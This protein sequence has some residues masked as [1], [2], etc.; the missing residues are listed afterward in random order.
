MHLAAHAGHALVIG[1]EGFHS[2]R[3]TIWRHQAGP[4]DEDTGLAEANIGG[5]TPEKFRSDRDQDAALVESVNRI[6]HHGD[7]L[8]GQARVDPGLERRLQNRALQN[9]MRRVGNF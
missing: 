8:S 4:A 1:A 6:A 5:V 3:L 7:Q 2:H 9:G